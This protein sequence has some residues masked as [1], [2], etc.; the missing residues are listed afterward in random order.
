MEYAF[1]MSRGIS[2]EDLQRLRRRLAELA[3]DERLRIKLDAVDSPQAGS[4]INLLT[5]NGYTYQPD[6]SA[7]GE[8]QYLLVRRLH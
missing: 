6:A 2:D 4:L 7:G 8:E 3:Q 1:D 5:S